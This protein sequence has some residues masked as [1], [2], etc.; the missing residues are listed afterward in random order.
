MAVVNSLFYPTLRPFAFSGLPATDREL[1]Y[2][3]SREI[4][5]YLDDT[6]AATGAGD[7]QRMNVIIS[8][9]QGFAYCL[10]DFSLTIEAA[11]GATHHFPASCFVNWYNAVS[12][13]GVGL[14]MEA[15]SDNLTY[16]STNNQESR[17]YRIP[18]VPKAILLPSG[19]SDQDQFRCESVNQ[20]ANDTA[21]TVSFFARFLEFS[22]EQAH[23]W[24]AN[25]P[26]SVR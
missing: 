15:V 11:V 1:S 10:V 3:P 18:V 26:Q 25:T 19:P 20:T 24:Q 22:V 5:C 14:T 6:I 9:L 7:N 23:N 12:T 17:T 21:Y 2:A 13:P 8:L 16:R 4:R